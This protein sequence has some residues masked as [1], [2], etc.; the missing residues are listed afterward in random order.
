M[1]MRL[2]NTKHNKHN[3]HNK[4]KKHKKK[5]TQ[6]GRGCS[7]YV[8]TPV[9]PVTASLPLHTTVPFSAI[10]NSDGLATAIQN[11]TDSFDKAMSDKDMTDEARQAIQKTAIENAL[12]FSTAMKTEYDKKKTLLDATNK[13]TRTDQQQII[14]KVFTSMANAWQNTINALNSA[15]SVVLLVKTSLNLITKQSVIKSCTHSFNDAKSAFETVSAHTTILFDNINTKSYSITTEE[16]AKAIEKQTAQAATSAETYATDAK[17]TTVKRGGFLRKKLSRKY[18]KKQ[19]KQKGGNCSNYVSDT[20]VLKVSPSFRNIFPSLETVSNINKTT[21]SK[22][23]LA[24]ESANKSEI[25]AN[26]SAVVAF[27]SFEK[28]SL[29]HT[30][31][32]EFTKKLESND[33]LFK[34][35]SDKLV[36]VSTASDKSAAA[37]ELAEQAVTNSKNAK[38]QAL[39]LQKVFDNVFTTHD[40]K[41]RAEEQ[42]IALSKTAETEA[43]NAGTYA[44]TAEEESK[45]A[46]IASADIGAMV[47]VIENVRKSTINPVATI[48]PL[49]NRNLNTPI[50]MKKTSSRVLS[51]QDKSLVLETRTFADTALP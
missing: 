38:T 50:T 34:T 16:N 27:A 9:V 23:I 14:L 30:E 49:L 36:I 24:I 28:A 32:V 26:K 31:A 15:D 17:S 40:N 25:Q 5:Y 19:T 48:N 35:A 22:V 29:Y 33:L 39:A 46:K 43:A 37:A 1:S 18:N 4:H 45:K 10:T 20:P 21:K 6:L 2:R 7:S 13:Q 8:S 44:Q 51:D 47:I 42:V 41:R 12:I 11:V 3:K